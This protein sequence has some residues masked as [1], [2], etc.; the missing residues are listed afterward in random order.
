MRSFSQLAR[1]AIHSQ[2]AYNAL[3]G[4]Y[5]MPSKPE[6]YP[7]LRS[8][9]RKSKKESVSMPNTQYVHKP[10]LS[11]PAVYII[12][13]LLNAIRRGVERKNI[14]REFRRQKIAL[15]PRLLFWIAICKQAGLIKEYEG[16]L[17]VSSY[18]RA[19]LNQTPEEQTIRL[20]EAWQDAPKNKKARQFR[21]K[22]LWKLKYDQ[23][24]SPVDQRSS[25]VDQRS[26]PVDK[27]LTRKDNDALNGLEALGLV[28]ENQLTR[29]GKFFVKGEGSLPTPKPVEPCR[30]SEDYFIAPVPQHTDLLWEIEKRLRPVMPGKYPL[31][32]RALSFHNEDPRTLIGLIEKGLQTEIPAR[33]KALILN[34]P[35]I[36]VAEGI[37]LEFSSPA[38]LAQLRRQP[39]FREYI[40]EFLSSQRVLVSSQKAKNLFQML[41]RRGVYLDQN[42]EQAEASRKRTH[43]PQKTLLQPIGKSVP[44][45]T[46]IEK[47]KQLGQA[48]D[49]L[50]RA[51]GYPA[52]QRRITPH[53]S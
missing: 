17:S 48:L 33:T 35:S 12:F 11:Y 24:S 13:T 28:S 27:P 53:A 43:F 1:F 9:V 25:P 16:R 7:A 47:Y 45:L 38:E 51:P 15:K 49:V 39:G 8:A 14:W 19:W 44:K 3:E 21:K 4:S 40:D 32:Q 20:I 37:V 23:R 36:R 2:S 22:L 26:S 46:L 6:T 29:W 34:Q 31:T 50:Y 41:K 42:E 10:S 52:E 5:P 18:A 30:I